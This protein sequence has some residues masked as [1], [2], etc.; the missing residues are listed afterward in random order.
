LKEGQAISEEDITAIPIPGDRDAMRRVLVPFANRGILLG[1]RATRNYE[2]GD[3]V[4]ARDLAAPSD[5]SDWEAIGPFELIS[6]GERFK[7]SDRDEAE[8]GNARGNTVTISV[9]RDFDSRTSRLLEAITSGRNRDSS[10]DRMTIIAVQ[11][12]PSPSTSVRSVDSPLTQS[13][14]DSA[15]K[16]RAVRPENVVYQTVSL[17]GIPNVPSVLLEGDWIRFVSQRN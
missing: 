12:F 2:R 3:V 11:V 16:Q 14:G 5:K 15:D 17:D 13:Y 4:Y 10:R 6:V 7:S 8:T 1:T 9:D